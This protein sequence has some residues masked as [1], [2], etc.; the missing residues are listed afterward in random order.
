MQQH[1]IIGILS[2]WDKLQA[3]VKMGLHNDYGQATNLQD[4]IDII[5][6]LLGVAKTVSPLRELFN[7]H[8]RDNDNPHN[9]TIDVNNIDMF[10]LL[11]D[12][13]T[14][15]HGALMTLQEFIYSMIN[16]KHF[17]SRSD[18]DAGIHLNGIM[19]VDSMQYVVANHD[20]SPDAHADLFRYKLPGIPL[21]EPPSV[22][23]EPSLASDKVLSVQRSSSMNYHD[24]NGRVRTAGPNKLALDYSYGVPSIPI[25]STKSNSLLNS[26]KLTDVGLIGSLSISPNSLFILTPTD[27]KDFLLLQEAYTVGKHGFIETLPAVSGI[28]NYSVYCQP[29]ERRSVVF[30][31]FD[32]T[33]TLLG[34]CKFN[35][36]TNDTNLELAV[37]SPLT[38]AHLE[39][40]ALPNGWFRCCI[41]FDS[42]NTNISTIFVGTNKQATPE[43]FGDTYYQGAIVHSMA[44]WQH[45]LTDGPTVVPPIFTE[46]VPNSFTETKISRDFTEGFNHD[47]GTVHVKY[48][49]TLNELYKTPYQVFRIGF[50]S[51]NPSIPN[52]TSIVSGVDRVAP[53]YMQIESFNAEKNTLSW[54]SSLPYKADDP[55][56]IKRVEFSYQNGYQSYGFT[57]NGPHLFSYYDPATGGKP[58][59]TYDEIDTSA[60]YFFTN[61]YDGS[62]SN[63]QGPVIVEIPSIFNMDEATILE[64]F[65]NIYDGSYADNQGPLLLQLTQPKVSD[66][67]V[68]TNGLLLTSSKDSLPQYKINP[69]VNVLEIGWNSLTNEFLEGYLLEFRYYSVFADK[70]NIEFL[71]DQYIP[72]N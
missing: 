66:Y 53:E 52:E 59:L 12:T 8:L 27:D 58:I 29:I 60:D 1:E 31:L 61:I 7:A 19:S 15:E 30:E 9:V 55:R 34:T 33:N 50:N 11:Y 36:N 42:R 70:M 54:I 69:N 5:H 38:T 23:V 48:I 65:T 26:K 71:L 17:V 22:V 44:F 4:V 28:N 41:G 13:Y 67:P 25:F 63:Q 20:T 39:I 47:K 16:V 64:F 21:S 35:L 18:I 72:E 3:T 68:D 37:G 2:D 10:G 14:A 40:I 32:N 24:I 46:L 57:D 43:E 62:Y 56:M 51:S 6:E 49:S 45:Q